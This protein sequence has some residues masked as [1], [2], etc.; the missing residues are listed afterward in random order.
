MQ[1]IPEASIDLIITDPPYGCTARCG[2]DTKIPTAPL[3][4][5]YARILSKNG[6]IALTATQPFA[7]DLINNTTVPFRYDIIWQKP[8]PGGYL[9]ANKMPLRSH[10]HILI[11]YNHLPTYNP[12]MTTGNP[13]HRKDQNNDTPIYNHCDRIPTHTKQRYSHI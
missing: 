1:E 7:T 11:F 10:E 3:L 6:V 9:N 13:Y 4:K 12:Q 8:N 2:W 5:E